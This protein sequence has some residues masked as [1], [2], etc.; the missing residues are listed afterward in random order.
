MDQEEELQLTPEQQEA[1]NK[2]LKNPDLIA[3]IQKSSELAD[4]KEQYHVVRASPLKCPH[5]SQWG[6]VGGSLWIVDGEKDHFVCRKC[7]LAFIVSCL[8]LPTNELIIKMREDKKK[9]QSAFHQPIED[10]PIEGDYAK[11]E[12]DFLEGPQR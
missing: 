12:T 10:K 7:K 2:L 1:L 6:Q 11:L 5:C 3:K 8:T 4:F 9:G